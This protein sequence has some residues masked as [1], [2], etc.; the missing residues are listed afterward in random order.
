MLLVMGR[1]ACDENRRQAS[2][3]MGAQRYSDS[4]LHCVASHEIFQ[5]ISSH[6]SSHVPGFVSGLGKSAML[7]PPLP[8]ERRVAVAV[9]AL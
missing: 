4:T 6:I 5:G 7:F 1:A 2:I 8:V 3:E 9:F